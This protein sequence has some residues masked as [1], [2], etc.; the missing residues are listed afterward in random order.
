MRWRLN[1]DLLVLRRSPLLLAL[2]LAY[3]VVVSVLLGVALSAGPEQPR[4]AVANLVDPEELEIPL[5]ASRVDLSRYAER[6]YDRIDPIHVDSREEA[7][8]L[9]RSGDALAALIVPA[10]LPRRLQGSLNLSGTAPPT[11]EVLYD[12]EDPVKRR[13]VES[14]VGA[15]LADANRALSE[16][17]LQ[18]AAQYLDVVVTGGE[19][20]FPLVGMVDVLGLERA[21][22]LVRAA[23]AGLDPD[24]PESIALGQVEHFA[25]LAADNLDLS[26]PV[27]ASIG[28]PVEVREQVIAG[29][30]SP[31]DAY[32]A[33][34]SVVVSLMLVAL[35]LAAGMLASERDEQVYVRLVRGLVSRSGLL[36]EKVA[37]A[38]LCALVVGLLMLSGLGLA[39]DFG[40]A[41]LPLWFLVLALA[42]L[43]FAAMG[44]AIGALARDVR[45]GALLAFAVS[46]PVVV[47]GLVPSGAVGGDAYGVVGAVSAAFPF[48][49]ALQGLDA[50]ISGGKLVA[51]LLH[52]TALTVAFGGLAR[53]LMPRLD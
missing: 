53:I 21:V 48:Q 34:L 40:F 45:T 19:V 16:L 35:L 33:A 2:L 29:S 50:A 43:A 6:L 24:S 47:L 7:I 44:V 17:V 15:Q 37:A 52:L 26:G 46:L 41:R 3:P 30:R 49:P 20:T 39:L 25:E 42:A 38:A 32:A 12:A 51:P 14:V 22:G 1:T 10:D 23:R 36:A 28:T 8:E 18:Q 31:L 13:Y 9:V 5:G 4:V 11:V 27:L